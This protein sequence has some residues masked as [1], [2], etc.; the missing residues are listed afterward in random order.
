MVTNTLSMCGEGKF[1]GKADEGLLVGYSVNSKAFKAF[2]TRNSKVKENLHIK[3]LE[4]KSN[5][6]GSGLE[7]LFDIDSLTKSMNY[8]LVTAGNQ[9]NGDAEDK[10]T[11]EVPGKGD[12]DVNKESGIYDQERTDSSTQDVN[13]VGPSIN[14][15]NA[16]IS[17]GSLNINTTSPIPNDPTMPSLE[18]TDIFDGTYDD[19][20]V[21][22]EAD[23]NNLETTMNVGPIPTTITHK[24]HPKD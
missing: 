24:D 8:E 17:T 23:L 6:I 13:T 10:D 14:I 22:A 3:F 20:D 7:W 21:G 9:T 12:D 16:N 11:D 19:E 1:E 4:N 15:A 18:E 2:N 5:V